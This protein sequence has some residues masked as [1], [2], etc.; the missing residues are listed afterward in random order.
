MDKDDEGAGGDIMSFKTNGASLSAHC[1][2]PGLVC[3]M[4]VITAIANRLSFMVSSKL[5]T[6]HSKSFV[7][8][9]IFFYP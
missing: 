9:N 4:A 8:C 6:E 5:I 7:G 1:L 3:C 2:I